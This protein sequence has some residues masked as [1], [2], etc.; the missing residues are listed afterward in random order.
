MYYIGVG[1]VVYSLDFRKITVDESN[2]LLIDEMG[3]ILI[4]WH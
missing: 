4:K 2:Y 3:P 1:K